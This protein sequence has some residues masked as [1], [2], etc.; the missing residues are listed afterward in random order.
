MTGEQ[1][2]LYHRGGGGEHPDKGQYIEEFVSGRTVTG[3]FAVAMVGRRLKKDGSP[4]LRLELQ[5]RTGRIAAVAWEHGHLAS[6]LENGTILRVTGLVGT[7]QDKPQLTVSDIQVVTHRVP[8]EYFMTESREGREELGARLAKVLEGIEDEHL[9]RL[10]DEIFDGEGLREAWL[11]APAAKKKHQAYLGGLAE[12]SLNMAEHARWCAGFYPEINGDLLVTAALLHDIGK[13][14]EYRV[15]TVIDYS[16]TGRLEGHVVIGDR[17]VRRVADRIP[18]FPAAL[19]MHLSHLILSHQG[20]LEYGSPVLPKTLEALVL[21]ALDL[22]DSRVAAYRDIRESHR[23]EKR[24]WSDYDRLEER[25]W[26]LGLDG[27]EDADGGD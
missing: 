11:E 6:R 9:I 13:I 12:H 2:D 14:F 20:R 3:L 27:D 24:T 26:F 1:T 7:Y 21:Y 19:K 4:F 5:D 25:F 17:M 18:D 8:A 23:G 16:D 22:L 15:T 10:L